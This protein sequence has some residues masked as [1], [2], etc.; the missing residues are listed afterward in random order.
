MDQQTSRCGK[1][2][3]QCRQQRQEL[4]A[5]IHRGRQPTARP[6]DRGG[7]QISQ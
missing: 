7:L 2:S 3:R 1:G 4:K 5:L 6:H